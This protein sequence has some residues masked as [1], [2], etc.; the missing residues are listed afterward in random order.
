M[1]AY[2]RTHSPSRLAWSEGWRHLAPNHVHQMNRVNS[3]NDFVMMTALKTL[4][5]VLLLLL[6][7][8][9]LYL[10]ICL[11]VCDVQESEFLS[12]TGPSFVRTFL[13]S[14]PAWLTDRLAHRLADARNIDHNSLHLM[15]SMRPKMMK[16]KVNSQKVNKLVREKNKV[17]TTTEGRMRLCICAITHCIRLHRRHQSSQERDHISLL[18][19]CTSDWSHTETRYCSCTHEQLHS[20]VTKYNRLLVVLRMVIIGLNQQQ[21]SGEVSRQR[22]R[23]LE[24]N[25]LFTKFCFNVVMLTI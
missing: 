8:L 9:L 18:T 15:H 23:F 21:A 16:H 22:F 11:R 12:Q 20:Q 2:R 7:L 10:L 3:R 5:W 14:P 25:F 6:L 1:A 4:S 17:I 13:H 24:P 19:R